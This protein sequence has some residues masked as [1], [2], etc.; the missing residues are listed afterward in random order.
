MA[1]ANYD[2]CLDSHEGECAGDVEY[3]DALSGT[4]KSFQRCDA[5]WS[6]RLDVQ[7]GINQRY[8]AMAPSDFDPSYA[9]EHWDEDY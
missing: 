9:G 2:D 7:E 5:H 1:N 4:G 3:R 8:P 6:A